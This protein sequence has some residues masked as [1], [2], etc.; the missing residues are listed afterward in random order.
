MER[1][2]RITVT[3]TSVSSFTANVGDIRTSPC[4]TLMLEPTSAGEND[5]TTTLVFMI[6]KIQ[7]A[8]ELVSMDTFTKSISRVFFIFC[9]PSLRPRER[10][11]NIFN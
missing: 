8:L 9:F 11:R 1:P 6:R 3:N 5:P 4:K 2:P 7:S 10:A